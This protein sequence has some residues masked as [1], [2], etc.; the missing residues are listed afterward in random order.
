MNLAE[1]ASR[2]AED[3]R[4]TQPVETVLLVLEALASGASI[5]GAAGAAD[6]NYD[7][8]QRISKDALAVHHSEPHLTAVG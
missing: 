4:T 8:A 6:V 1:F 5:N 7:T 2:V 3:G